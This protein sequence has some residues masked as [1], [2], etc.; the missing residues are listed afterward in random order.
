MR[1]EPS[2]KDSSLSN[3][4]DQGIGCI[5]ALGGPRS[6][7]SVRAPCE[8]SY[9]L[10]TAADRPPATYLRAVRGGSR[11]GSPGGQARS[12]PARKPANFPVEGVGPA[13][14]RLLEDLRGPGPGPTRPPVLARDVHRFSARRQSSEAPEC[15]RALTKVCQ[16]FQRLMAGVR[17]RCS[18]EGLTKALARGPGRQPIR[19]GQ[20]P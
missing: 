18:R 11:E 16:A 7:K 2:R 1:S 10:A 13:A 14:I 6:S 9:C 8:V 17:R 19:P 12:S 3:W 4:G 15:V 5:S 20:C